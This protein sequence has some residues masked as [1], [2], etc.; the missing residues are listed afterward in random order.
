VGAN[1]RAACNARSRAEFIAK[2]CI[3]IEEADESVFWLELIAGTDGLLTEDV[4]P[5][6]QEAVELRAI[7]SRSVGT[8]R[9]NQKQRK[10]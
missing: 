7:F 2:L 5:T 1:Y 8:A 10:G 3:V 6:R 9:L 4:T